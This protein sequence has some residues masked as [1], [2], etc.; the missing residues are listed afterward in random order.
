IPDDL[1]AS[2]MQAEGCVLPG[3]GVHDDMSRKAC[4]R[5]VALATQKVMVDILSDAHEHSLSRLVPPATTDRSAYMSHITLQDMQSALGQ[6]GLS[7]EDMYVA[8]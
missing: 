1:V 6:V 4:I 7:M 8:P 2:L 5:A 3:D